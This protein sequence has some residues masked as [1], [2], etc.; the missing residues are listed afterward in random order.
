MRIPSIILGLA[1]SVGWGSDS[2]AESVTLWQHND[3]VVSLSSDGPWRQFYYHAPKPELRPLGVEP[4]RLLFAG[5]RDGNQYSGIAYIFHRVCGALPYDVAGAVSPDDRVVTM[6]GKNP[7]V[8]PN[9][10]VVGHQNDKLVFTYSGPLVTQNAPAQNIPNQQGSDLEYDRFVQQWKACFEDGRLPNYAVSMCDLA[11][12]FT[13]LA[14]EDRTLLTQ[15][16]AKL[17]QPQPPKEQPVTREPPVGVSTAQT[18]I[19]TANPQ[20]K[21]PPLFDWTVPLFIGGLVLTVAIGL[22]VLGMR[23][24]LSS[25]RNTVKHAPAGTAGDGQSSTSPWVTPTSQTEGAGEKGSVTSTGPN[26]PPEPPSQSMSLKL[27]RSQKPGSFGKI[28]FALDARIGL[29]AG[30][31]RLSTNTGSAAP[32]FTTARNERNTGRR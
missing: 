19:R 32:L 20:A 9:C 3:S 4:G 5:R 15:R 6:Y 18:V 24:D 7:V 23:A 14:S 12:A 17:V 16:R 30:N 2:L 31:T 29:N 1:L 26:F 10:Q 27:K 11:L 8:D 13:R 21:S 25:A 28:I 22:T